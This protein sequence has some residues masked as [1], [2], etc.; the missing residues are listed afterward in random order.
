MHLLSIDRWISPRSSALLGVVLILSGVTI[1]VGWATGN[2]GATRLYFEGA[3]ISII[4]AVEFILSGTAFI[5]PHVATPRV[6]RPV[7]R[8]IAAFMLGLSTFGAVGLCSDVLTR[9]LA[10]PPPMLGMNPAAILL[11]ASS[12]WPSKHF[13]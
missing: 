3:T 4:G 5:V 12:A 7:H 13:F 2:V 10:L 6:V 11:T 9:H 8:L 1:C